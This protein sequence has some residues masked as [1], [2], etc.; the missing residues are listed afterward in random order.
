MIIFSLLF[1]IVGIFVFS[2]LIYYRELIFL[3]EELI[4]FVIY[5]TITVFALIWCIYNLIKNGHELWLT[6]V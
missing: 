6:L 2:I 4:E 1:N 3:F 5:Y